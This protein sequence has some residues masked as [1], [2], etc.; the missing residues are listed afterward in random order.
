MTDLSK[1]NNHM[2]VLMTSASADNLRVERSTNSSVDPGE[3]HTKVKSLCDIVFRNSASHKPDLSHLL[4]APIPR[5]SGLDVGFY[6]TAQERTKITIEFNIYCDR[7]TTTLAPITYLAQRVFNSGGGVAHAMWSLFIDADGYF[8][9]SIAETVV[10]INSLL[11]INEEIA[12]W[13]HVAV[14]MDTSSSVSSAYGTSAVVVVYFDGK[15]VKQESFDVP[16]AAEES[17]AF[18][19]LYVCPNMG[20]GWRMTEFRIWSDIRDSIEIERERD[21]YLSLASKRKRLQLRVLTSKSFFGPFDE[22]IFNLSSTSIIRNPSEPAEAL[23]SAAPSADGKT[24]SK[25]KP[26]GMLKK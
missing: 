14:T 22:S 7:S 2:Y 10:K 11:I 21:N 17:I 16:A 9:V 18:T 3:D 19:H 24:A 5:G 6:H 4:Y 20:S 12:V 25:L 23:V 26:L 1:Y 15:W 8:S 13:H